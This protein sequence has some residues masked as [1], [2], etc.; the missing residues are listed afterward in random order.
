MNIL[1]LKRRLFGRVYRNEDGDGGAGGSM[2]SSDQSSGFGGGPSSG[3]YGDSGWGDYGGTAGDAMAAQQAALAEAQSI[4]GAQ[5][6]AQAAAEQAAAQAAAA[7]AARQAEAARV[8]AAASDARQAQTMQAT[9]DRVAVENTALADK[10]A[11]DHGWS[12]AKDSE[13][14]NKDMASSFASQFGVSPEVATR[15]IG[16]ANGITGM[17]SPNGMSYSDAQSLSDQGLGSL[18][19]VNENN[20]TQSVAEALASK[21][22]ND[23]IAP[24]MVGMIKAAVPYSGLAMGLAKTA[25][26]V[27]SG[28]KT[29]GGA[30]KDTAID[31]GAGWAAGQINSAIGG[32]I[33]QET[34]SG[35]KAASSVSGLFGGPTMPNIGAGLVN[36]GLNAIGIS[37]S[38]GSGYTSTH[39]DAADNGFVRDGTTYG[40]GGSSG[41]FQDAP[42]SVSPA[43][44]PAPS[45]ADGPSAGMSGVNISLW[46]VD[47]HG[48]ADA[49][50]TYFQNKGVIY[51]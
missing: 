35:L 36:T 39:T 38:T 11:E 22:F 37:K 8:E 12:A 5:A 13:K 7:E 21:N 40:T 20:K 23:N 2:S 43:T 51:G 10:A 50:K 46:D 9:Q 17:V 29:L 26:Q 14:A 49:K 27:T 24:A 48:W 41:F 16:N 18:M 30:L 28:E 6:A 19:G 44:A 3:S 31:I 47:G 4:A 1:D 33:G 15:A 34:M 45:V 25:G 42:T 32:L